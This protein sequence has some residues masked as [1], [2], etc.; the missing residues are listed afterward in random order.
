MILE[1]EMDILAALCHCNC[2]IESN[3]SHCG[4][5][6]KLIRNTLE[7]QRVFATIYGANTE[8]THDFVILAAVM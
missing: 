6:H 7:A 5:N 8:I 2:R 1:I 4:I 3:Y